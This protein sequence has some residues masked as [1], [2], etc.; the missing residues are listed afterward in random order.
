MVLTEYRYV[1]KTPGVCGGSPV[2]RNT[3]TPVRTIVGYYKQG[4]SVEEMLEGLPHLSAAQIYEALS[5]YHD[6]VSEIENDLAANQVEKVLQQQ[7]L[8]IAEDGRIVLP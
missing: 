4:M 3:R 6:N 8:P 5:Y 7:G 2:I 1:T